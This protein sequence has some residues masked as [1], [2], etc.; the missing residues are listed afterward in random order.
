MVQ[1]FTRDDGT[2]E[3]GVAYQG[4]WIAVVASDQYGLQ[5]GARW[6]N[7]TGSPIGHGNGS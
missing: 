4:G 6:N 3:V 7:G 2:L 5:E 1:G